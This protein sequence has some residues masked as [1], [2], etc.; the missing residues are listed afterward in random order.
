MAECERVVATNPNSAEGYIE[1]AD[2][3]T[4]ANRLEEAVR[5][6]ENASRIDPTR[7]EFYAYFIASPYVLMGRYNEAI[8]LLEKHIAVYPNQPF[9]HIM[10][11]VA[12]TELGRDEDARAEAAKIM[13]ENPRFVVTDVEK[14]NRDPAI[15]RRVAGDL[16]KAGLK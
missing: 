14:V 10:L 8:P 3:L 4:A 13:R 15:S 11:L 6:V 16:R 1:L 9:A 5:A 7:P 2:A 12:Y